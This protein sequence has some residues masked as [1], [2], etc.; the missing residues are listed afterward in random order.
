MKRLPNNRAQPRTQVQ[1]VDLR[2]ALV[3]RLAPAPELRRVVEPTTLRKAEAA[4][5]PAA[6]APL[7]KALDE[8]LAPIAKGIDDATKH[9][10]ELDERSRAL[11]ALARAHEP[12]AGLQ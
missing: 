1:K 6:L 2:L 7:Q 5:L 11:D 3:K 9:L 10:Q 8:A 4:S 12:P